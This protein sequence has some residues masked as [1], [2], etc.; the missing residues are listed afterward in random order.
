MHT[1]A[2]IPLDQ[3]QIAIVVH[4]G[5]ARDLIDRSDNANA[6][7]VAALIDAGVSITLCGQT[8]V[9]RGISASDLLPG[10]DMALS[11]MTKHALLQQDGYTLNPF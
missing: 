9:H 3:I 2:G 5:A 4:G 1:E 11:A 6:P 8:A 7:L 10:V